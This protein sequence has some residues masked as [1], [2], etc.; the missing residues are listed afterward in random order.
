MEL[1]LG[2]SDVRE[3]S[4]A[5]RLEWEDHKCPLWRE[6]ICAAFECWEA[7]QM[8]VRITADL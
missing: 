7:G 8:P 6:K 3:R 5:D 2:A 4:V 1:Y